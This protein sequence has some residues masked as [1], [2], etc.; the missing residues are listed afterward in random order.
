MLN[1]LRELFPVLFLAGIALVAFAAFWPIEPRLMQYSTMRPQA[2]FSDDDYER[3]YCY[4]YM[5]AALDFYFDRERAGPI[6]DCDL[7]AFGRG[8]CSGH[9]SAVESFMLHGFPE[10]DVACFLGEVFALRNVAIWSWAD[11]SE[12]LDWSETEDGQARIRGQGAHRSLENFRE[13]ANKALKAEETVS[14]RHAGGRL[15]AMCAI[16][17]RIQSLWK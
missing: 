9:S 3:G 8:E 13:F 1:F 2:C 4:G 7:D 10:R 15:P 5:I 17:L 14:A 16:S 6:S 11:V 12:T